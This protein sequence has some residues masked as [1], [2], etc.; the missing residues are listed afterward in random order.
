MGMYAY[1]ENGMI[2][3]VAR[4]LPERWKH[5]KLHEYNEDGL[6][7]L[8]WWPVITTE[9]VWDFKTQKLVTTDT[10]DTDNRVVIRDIQVVDKTPQEI[11]RRQIGQTHK[12]LSKPPVDLV[13]ALG[14][15]VSFLETNSGFSSDSEAIASVK[16]MAQAITDA[17][18]A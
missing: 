18:G 5:H 6:K 16:E 14:E 10:I 8:G 17:G 3:R 12:K 13:L 7:D 4:S 11:A 2:R 15:I 9:P 1:L